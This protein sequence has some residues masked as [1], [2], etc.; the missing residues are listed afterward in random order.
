MVIQTEHVRIWR[1]VGVKACRCP[2]SSTPE[3]GQLPWNL[4]LAIEVNILF[5]MKVCFE[6]IGWNLCS[7]DGTRCCWSCV[8]HI[9]ALQN[10][11]MVRDFKF[12]RRW[13]TSECGSSGFLLAVR[14]PCIVFI[15][16][17]FEMFLTVRIMISKI[18]AYL[19]YLRRL[20]AVFPPR[21]PGFKPG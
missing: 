13:V 6:S 19:T 14:L 12:S 3:L 15:T 17:S 5:R 1:R 4:I 2:Y 10:T 8:Q 20:V 16:P 7:V 18:M 9:V 21:W 11:R